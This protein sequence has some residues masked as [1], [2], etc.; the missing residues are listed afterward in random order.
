MAQASPVVSS[1]IMLPADN[2]RKLLAWVEKSSAGDVITQA[3]LERN[4]PARRRPFFT[5]ETPHMFIMMMTILH[6]KIIQPEMNRMSDLC[7]I[8]L[9]RWTGTYN[10]IMRPI[11]L[12][13]SY[14]VNFPIE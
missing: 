6:P 8:K 10:C 11:P 5:I 2:Q 7:L 14:N 4:I 12:S 9:Q 1:A 3:E 13:I